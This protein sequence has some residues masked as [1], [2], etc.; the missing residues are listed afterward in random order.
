MFVPLM[1]SVSIIVLIKFDISST[2][3]NLFKD[4]LFFTFC[5]TSSGT[6]SVNPPSK[7]CTCSHLTHHTCKLAFILELHTMHYACCLDW[8]ASP[9]G[10]LEM[11]GRPLSC[12]RHAFASMSHLKTESRANNDPISLHCHHFTWL[13]PLQPG[14]RV[15]LQ[16]AVRMG[17]FSKIAPCCSR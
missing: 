12:R 4:M 13:T 3:P 2:L 15:S 6:F 17:G 14:H 9:L 7:S 10:S 1:Y 5:K 16:P 8:S 11:C